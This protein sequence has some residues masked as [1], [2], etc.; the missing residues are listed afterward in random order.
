MELRSLLGR[1]PYISKRTKR[2]RCALPLAFLSTPPTALIVV[3]PIVGR[4]RAANAGANSNTNVNANA[5]PYANVNAD[6]NSNAVSVCKVE[7]SAV[8]VDEIR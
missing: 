3:L 5:N 8:R 2:Q 7:H 6:D 1:N 4:M